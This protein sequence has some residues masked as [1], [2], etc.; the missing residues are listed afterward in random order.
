MHG[1]IYASP[2]ISGFLN[3]VWIDGFL[4]IFVVL[5]FQPDFALVAPALPL[6]ANLTFSNDEGVLRNT[7]A[8]MALVLPVV[9]GLRSCFYV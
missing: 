4:L 7:L 2:W 3:Q 1:W 6:I 9:P 8:A 5:I